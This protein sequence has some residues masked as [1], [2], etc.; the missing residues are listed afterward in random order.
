MKRTTIGFDTAKRI[1]QGHRV[2][3]ATGEVSRMKLRRHEVLAHFAQQQPAVIVME[4]CGGSQYWAR[5]LAKLGHETRL[6]APQFVRPF[7][8][9]NKNDAA[10]ARAI[11]TAAQQPEMRFVP[12][13]TE[14]QQ[15]VLGLHAIRARLQK[16][17][18][19]AIN[20]IHGLMGEFGVALPKGRMMRPRALAALNDE[21]SPV[22]ALLRSVLRAQFEEIDALAERIKAVEREL[23]AWHRQQPDCQRIDAIPGVAFLT[24]TAAVATIGQAR[25]FRSGRQF[26]ASVGLVPRHQGTGGRVKLL[27]ISKRGDTYL[28]TLLID[29]ARS[30]LAHSPAAADPATWLGRLRQRRP[31][32]VATVAL[33]NKMARQIWALLAH[34]R[35][36]EANH[37]PVSSPAAAAPA[38]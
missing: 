4:A 20:E 5:E 26:A 11:W 15:A 29:G 6:I 33:A 19:A 38:A 25:T 30:V 9:G 3:L 2:D 14:E 8:K 22:P 10:D 7:V 28:R 21:A 27:G 12:V 31:Y 16:H 37:V 24:A 34:Q 35:T 36:Y 13:K 18:T 17:R 32:N 23:A 1:F